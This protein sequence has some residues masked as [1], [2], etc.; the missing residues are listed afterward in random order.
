MQAGDERFP[1]GSE[2]ASMSPPVENKSGAMQIKCISCSNI[3]SGDDIVKGT[4]PQVNLEVML[5][6]PGIPKM[7]HIS[8][9]WCEMQKKISRGEETARTS[10]D[11]C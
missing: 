10:A 1:R 6:I 8:F 11:C 4:A 7:Q 9:F 2:S 3:I 5:D